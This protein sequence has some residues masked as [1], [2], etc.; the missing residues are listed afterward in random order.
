MKVL[1][2]FFVIIAILATVIVM[3]A[4]AISKDK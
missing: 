2:V 3:A 1:I 4:V